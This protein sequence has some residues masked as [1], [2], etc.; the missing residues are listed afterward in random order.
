MPGCS[1]CSS[2]E[3]TAGQLRTRAT[4]PPSSSRRAGAHG[5]P[6]PARSPPLAAQDPG[7]LSQSDGLAESPC[8]S[9]DNNILRHCIIARDNNSFH[10]WDAGL[11]FL[12]DTEI[13][14]NLFDVLHY[15]FTSMLPLGKDRTNYMNCMRKVVV[16]VDIFQDSIRARDTLRHLTRSLSTLLFSHG[17]NIQT[18][19][20]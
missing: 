13:S 15:T 20:H 1:R 12:S 7:P 11:Q 17:H 18:R 4:T 9:S 8:D 10:A 3:I 16:N 6:A 14:V 5:Q 2:R 19:N